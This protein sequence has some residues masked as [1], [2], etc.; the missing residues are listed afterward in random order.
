MNRRA[1]GTPNKVI[2]RTMDIVHS[3]SLFTWWCQAEVGLATHIHIH[4]GQWVTHRWETVT[5]TTEIDTVT[6]IYIPV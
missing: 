1:M 3:T 2:N 5:V 6:G 4:Y